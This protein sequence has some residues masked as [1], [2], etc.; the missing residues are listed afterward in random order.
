MRHSISGARTQAPLSARLNE[1]CS[2]CSHARDDHH[3]L[4][5]QCTCEL[6]RFFDE[7]VHEDNWCA[8][9]TEKT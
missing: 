7:R 8:F 9:W 6:S 2:N 4:F 1:S 5:V 3:L